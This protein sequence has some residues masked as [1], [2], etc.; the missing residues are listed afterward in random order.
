MHASMHHLMLLLFI[1]IFITIY[2]YSL[3]IIIIIVLLLLFIVNTITVELSLTC[4]RH[5]ILQFG[6]TQLHSRSL[7]ATYQIKRLRICSLI[8]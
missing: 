3:F 2:I 6:Q 8:T 4:Q 7:Y 1:V 5:K